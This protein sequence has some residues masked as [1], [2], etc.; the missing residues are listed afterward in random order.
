ML[1]RF[2][3]SDLCL[4]EKI[5]SGTPNPLV[6]F[7]VTTKQPMQLGVRVIYKASLSLRQSGIPRTRAVLT[8]TM[9]TLAWTIKIHMVHMKVFVRMSMIVQVYAIAQLLGN[10]LR[11]TKSH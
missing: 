3:S 9:G 5:G 4:H 6:S 8:I 2:R 11:L 7:L 10:L 1:G